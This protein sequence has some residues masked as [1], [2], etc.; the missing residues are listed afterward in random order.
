MRIQESLTQI[1]NDYAPSKEKV[2][3]AAVTMATSAVALE[4]LAAIPG[5]SAGPLTYALCVAA[6]SAAAPPAMPA[7]LAMCAIGLAPVM[8]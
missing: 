8:P 7:C 3:K 4:A 5:V 6:C 2:V 1:Y